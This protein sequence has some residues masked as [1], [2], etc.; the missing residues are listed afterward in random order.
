MA[1]A[2]VHDIKGSI[3][4]VLANITSAAE[5]AG[6]AG[7]VC[8][9]VPV[10]PLYPELFLISALPCTQV[11]LLT[12]SKTFGPAAIQTAYETGQRHFGENY[13]RVN[14]RVASCVSSSVS[15]V[16]SQSVCCGYR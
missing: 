16:I 4:T 5:R 7:K 12:V 1:S 11:R 10:Q 15:A 9:P 13:V 6:R 14:M 3:A 2:A 8:H